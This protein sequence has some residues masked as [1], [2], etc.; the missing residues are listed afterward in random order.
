MPKKRA[1]SRRRL[2]SRRPMRTAPC[3]SSRE[4]IASCGSHP[5]TIKGAV[6]RRSPVEVIPVVEQT[7]HI[8]IPEDEIRVDVSPIKGPGGQGVNTTGLAVRLTTYPRAS[9][10]RVRTNAHNPEQGKRWRCCKQTA[11]PQT[12]SKNSRR[13]TRSRATHPGRGET[14]CVP[15]SPAPVSD[16]QGFVD[17][18]GDW[19]HRRRARR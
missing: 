5:S 10:C 11:R 1:S 14:K 19:Q 6:R 16:G 4:H 8:E 18:A 12:T 7:D 2:R 13:S 17:R 15:I 3:L 9:S